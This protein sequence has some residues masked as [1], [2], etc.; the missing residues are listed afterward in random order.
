M[1]MIF[2][3]VLLLCI[4]EIAGNFSWLFTM[5]YIIDTVYRGKWVPVTTAWH[6]LMLR[7]EER[8]PI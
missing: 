8:P 1:T 3:P 7:M 5:K 6:I 4:A 2:I